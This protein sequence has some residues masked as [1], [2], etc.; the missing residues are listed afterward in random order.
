MNAKEVLDQYSDMVIMLDDL[1]VQKERLIDSVLTP[2]IKEKLQE[3][4]EEFA[5]KFDALEEKKGELETEVKNLVAQG[6]ETVRGSTHMAVYSKPRISWDTKMLEG[7]MMVIPQIADARKI[8]D[9][10]VS[11][12]VLK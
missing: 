10:S 9:P 2:E 3:I 4:E 5:Q 6:G 1:R 11:I 7:L 8:G 12:R